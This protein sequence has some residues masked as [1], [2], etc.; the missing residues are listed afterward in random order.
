MLSRDDRAL[1]VLIGLAIGDA[2]GAPVEFQPP[3]AIADRRDF[4]FSYPGGGPFPWAPG[5]FTDDTQ[6]ALVLARHLSAT[7]GAIDQA[8]L[9][10]EFAAWAAQ[11]STL[12]VGIQTSGVLSRISSGTPWR[13]ATATVESDR[14]G[15][16]SL[17]RVAPV[18]LAASTRDDAARLAELQSV[19]THPNLLSIDGCRA[20]AAIVWAELNDNP[21][22]VMNPTSLAREPQVIEAIGRALEPAAP[23]MSGFVVDTLCAALWAVHHATNFEDAVWAAVSLGHDADT[24]GAV[25]GAL[26]GARWGAASISERLKADL[27]SLN[28]MFVDEYPDALESLARELA[29]IGEA[30]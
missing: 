11:P 23:A 1:G 21:A 24:V 27:T 30:S 29:S 3:A 17:M 9:A 12:D 2:V 6:M 5:E 4:V 28:P 26:A 20:Y 19:V 25:T 18:A 8:A 14:E 10:G 16:G 7:R 22:D 13:D 15:N